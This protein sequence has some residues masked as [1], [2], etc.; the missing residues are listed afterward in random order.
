MK[1]H[2]RK[3]IKGG[4][5]STPCYK[6]AEGNG[7]PRLARRERRALKRDAKKRDIILLTGEQAMEFLE[8]INALKL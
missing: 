3:V 4:V 7:S 2:Y 6:H 1:G 5:N 8:G